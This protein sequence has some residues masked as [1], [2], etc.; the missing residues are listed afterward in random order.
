[1]MKIA[2]AEKTTQNKTKQKSRGVLFCF[3]LFLFLF[4]FLFSV[5]LPFW[6]TLKWGLNV[7]LFDKSKYVRRTPAI[8]NHSIRT[9]T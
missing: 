7:C 4:L 1:M 9:M 5:V 6:G 8:T 2:V 3:G